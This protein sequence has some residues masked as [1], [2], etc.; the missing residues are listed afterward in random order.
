MVLASP[1]ASVTAVLGPTNTGKTHLAIERM[2]GHRNGVIG[3]P[4]RL[5]ARENY[6]K[7]V[8]R[9]GARAVALVTGEE[10]IV[11][12]DAKYFVC[13]VEAMPLDRRFEFLA[14]DEVQIAGEQERG[15]VF[16]DRLMHAR[17]LDETMLLGSE[18]IRPLLKR[19]VPGARFETRPRLSELSYSG[20][21]KMTRLPRRSAVVAF[22][23]ADVYAIAEV[24]RRQRGGVAVVMGALSP[25]TRNAQVQM[26][27]EGDVD[28]LVATDAIGM[29]LNMDIDHVF[30]ASD[31][32]FDGR[33]PRR[34]RAAELAQIAGRAGRHMN[35]GTFGVTGNCA[36]LDDEAVMAIESHTFDPLKQLGWRNTRLDFSTIRDLKRSLDIWPE[37][38]F[39]SRKRD[40]E[41]QE[42]LETLSRM[43]DVAVRATSPARIRLLWD[44]CQIPDFQK[45]L[46]ESHAR[47]LAQVYLYLTD[48]EEKLPSDWV[49]GQMSRF[50]RTEGDIDTLMGRIAH[51]RTWT[52]ITHRGDWIDD[53]GHWQSRA[54]AI[55]DRL[56][57]AL[58]QQLTL[59]FVDRRSATLSR[60]LKGDKED[61]LAGVSGDGTVTVEGHRVGHLEG[62]SFQPDAA[63]TEE[64]KQV[65][66]AAR[67][68]LPDEIARRV[69]RLES[70]L[71]EVFRLDSH[72]VFF[73]RGHPVA[74]L[75][76]GD[77]AWRP[78]VRVRESDM[79]EP[80]QRDR[81]HKRLR[82]WME[83]HLEAVV[84]QLLQLARSDLSG[85]ARGIVFQ[86]LEG[87]G[88][89]PAE[90]LRA[91]VKELD[92]QGRKDLARVGIRLG[93]ENLYIPQLLKPKAVALRGLLW[94]VQHGRFPEEGLPPEGRVQVVRRA[95]TPTEY[96]V[97]LGYQRL[98]GRAIRIDMVERIAALIRQ[99]AR[100]GPF[101]INPDMLSLAGV[102]H[103]T[104]AAILNDLGYRKVGER[105]A[106]VPQ[107]VTAA[108]TAPETVSDT[109]TSAVTP[110]P[111]EAGTDE[112]VPAE[113][114]S[115]EAAPTGS[116]T[117]EGATDPTG[118]MPDPVAAESLAMP[119]PEEDGPAS[120]AEPVSAVAVE[121][122]PQS[123]E[124]E[125]EPVTSEP[126][127][128]EAA[129][130]EAVEPEAQPPVDITVAE[131]APG[132]QDQA[133]STPGDVVPAGPDV[134]EIQVG[135]VSSA[136]AEDAG[137]AG[138]T[139]VEAEAEPVVM[140]PLF[141]RRR[142]E[143]GRRPRSN[144]SKRQGE[145][146][147]DGAPSGE[148]RQQGRPYQGRSAQSQPGQGQGQ[149]GQAQS[150]QGQPPQGQAPQGRSGDGKPSHGKPQHARHGQGDG[151]GQRSDGRRGKGGGPKRRDGDRR[152]RDGR[153]DRPRVHTAEPERKGEI[154]PDSPFAALAGLRDALRKKDG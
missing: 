89:A 35:D 67:R 77:V 19:L 30:F 73:W 28:Y 12:P 154:D 152:G 80:A 127:A 88:N 145:Q 100:N 43:A 130:S 109:E 141:A 140:V 133:D 122:S 10:K 56:S 21:C 51:I 63:N 33:F 98:G 118:A 49:D 26:Y 110:V 114:V 59:R 124:P 105:P 123:V 116:D 60:K 69:S 120:D 39:L 22:S 81:M 71:D 94:S 68:V 72:G 38:D 41:D 135:D 151:G 40:G 75:V 54:R 148:N 14:V 126:A 97:A 29:G 85:G 99:A 45:H 117:V 107:A 113:T 52:Y 48:A 6:D 61:I 9:K 106:E 66:T 131:A 47:L 150:G 1:A 102:D 42:A 32:K 15:H 104:F 11:P 17:G 50:D 153:D 86:V 70:D 53:A 147:A 44:V 36:P 13:T 31:R 95:E 137:D 93:T 58:H 112:A 83:A 84:P 8:A 25:R 128:S 79:L 125:A 74:D 76:A 24:V 111:T 20:L 146:R 115:A 136:P 103:E 101:P 7:I 87:L 134:E 144:R 96:D 57:D 139:D 23:A 46:T 34:L 18:T 2:L 5:L 91:M 3:F 16:T 143:E 64:E 82:T 4:L 92:D 78:D 27:Q 62:F 149:S 119:T 138:A 121:D 129:A 55:E 65:M 132:D 37:H 90:G 108:G 142:R